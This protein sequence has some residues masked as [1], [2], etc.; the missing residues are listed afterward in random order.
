L[1]WLEDAPVT[2]YKIHPAADLFPMLSD[3]ELVALKN[4]I[5]A[6]GQHFPIITWNGYIIDGRNRLK[7]CQMAGE[8]PKFKEMK[9]EGETAA[10]TYII[11]TNI[12]RRHLTESQRSMIAT[13]LAKLEQGTR[14]VESNAQICASGPALTQQQAADSLN[15]SRRAVQQAKAVAKADLSVA[16]CRLI[17][18]RASNPPRPMTPR[19]NR[20]R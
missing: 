3:D 15:V 16:M 8:R 7:A 20:P 9:F 14:Q 5:I 17:G 6:S 11:S 10:V 19:P 1:G 18:I 4:S 12:T 13:E 2:E